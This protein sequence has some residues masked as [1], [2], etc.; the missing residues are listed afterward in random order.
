MF[1][2]L[3]SKMVFTCF[4]HVFVN[5]FVILLAIDN[6]RVITSLGCISES[7]RCRGRGIKRWVG[8]RILSSI[9]VHTACKFAGLLID[10]ASCCNIRW[11]VWN[12]LCPFT[13]DHNCTYWSRKPGWKSLS[14]VSPSLLTIWVCPVAAGYAYEVRSQSG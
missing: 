1:K 12:L 6:L 10:P 3:E 8:K 14:R 4:A 9:A 13:S 11:A 5:T 2:I 7:N